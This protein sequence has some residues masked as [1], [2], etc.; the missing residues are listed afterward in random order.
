MKHDNLPIGLENGVVFKTVHGSH[1]YGLN[2][3]DSDMDL[4]IV[5]TIPPVKNEMGDTRKTN[6]LQTVVDGLDV[7]LIDFKTFHIQASEGVPQALEAMFSR[8]SELDLIGAWRAGFRVSLPAMMNRYKHAIEKFSNYEFKRRRHAV[9]YVLN[10]REALANGGRFNPTMSEKD[11]EFMTS[12]SMSPNYVQDLQAISPIELAL[13]P[14]RIN[15][16][17]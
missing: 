12:L 6:S 17:V 8:Q 11:R 15:P 3:A 7:T 9:R 14:T 13:D 10:L 4:Y 1:L 2:H 5:H 16:L